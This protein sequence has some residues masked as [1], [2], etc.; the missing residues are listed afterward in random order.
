MLYDFRV[1]VSREDRQHDQKGDQLD[2]H[3][4]ID[5][6]DA[7]V[8]SQEKHLLLLRR[9]DV[10]EEHE[11]EGEIDEVHRLNQADDREEPGH[12]PS[13]RLWL[14]R[15]PTDEGVSSEAVTE[16]GADRAQPYGEAERYNGAGENESLVC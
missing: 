16:G 4:P 9:W 1:L 13:P 3:C 15:D 12:H 6:Y 11:A 5:R 14:P 8:G 7:R 2:D 10:R